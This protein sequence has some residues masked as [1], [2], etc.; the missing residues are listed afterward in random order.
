MIMEI[1]KVEET[2]RKSFESASN[3]YVNPITKECEVTISIDDY[4]GELSSKMYENGVC[5]E[6]VDYCD[7]YPFK[8]VFKYTVK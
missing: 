3:I 7:V 4:Q 2:L 5:L 6:M 1:N 8:Y